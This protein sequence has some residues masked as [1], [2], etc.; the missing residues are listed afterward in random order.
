MM[1]TP[2][3]PSLPRIPS[4]DDLPSL[5]PMLSIPL[6][7]AAA[8]VPALVGGCAP[9]R[10]VTRVDPNTVVDVNQQ[11]NDVD[12]RQTYQK[13]VQDSLSRPWIDNFMGEHGG[14]RPVVVVGPVVL[15]TLRRASRR[16]SFGA[17][18]SFAP[19]P[20]G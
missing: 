7:A 12:A 9:T 11:F 4:L 16:A 8:F 19:P 5:A 10:Q 20:A 3:L 15:V 17:P 13:M 1:N 14:R 2:R 6:M 18:V